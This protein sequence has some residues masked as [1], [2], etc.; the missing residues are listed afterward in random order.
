MNNPSSITSHFFIFFS[1]KI[2]GKKADTFCV[3]NGSPIKSG[4]TRRNFM[5]KEKILTP[6]EL[7]SR[8]DNHADFILVDVLPAHD[9]LKLHVTGAINIPLQELE[10][11]ANQ[12]LNR[13]I[14][15][16]VYSANHLCRG[17]EFAQEIL[18]KMGFRVWA[19]EGGLDS[20]LKNQFHVEGDPN[21]KPNVIT[22]PPQAETQP[23]Q[24]AKQ[25][26]VVPLQQP[27]QP[28]Q[29]QPKKKAA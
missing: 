10:T 7:K 8:M 20:W 16:I 29:Q 24:P 27:Q 12:W 18:S 28:K 5:K 23:K 4:M 11:K 22:A 21:Y 13:H 15:I 6:E 9:Y 25:S 26:V 2:H 3:N 14:D 17:A 1:L 19:L